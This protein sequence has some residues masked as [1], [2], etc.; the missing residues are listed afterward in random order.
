MIL[1]SAGQL[2]ITFDTLSLSLYLSLKGCILY[3][4]NPTAPSPRER[5]RI[6]KANYI[7]Q[8]ELAEHA[9]TPIISPLV[10]PPPRLRHDG[11]FGPSPLGFF[12][13]RGTEDVVYSNSGFV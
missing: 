5:E 8:I 12:G 4:T 2:R 9:P 13:A 7:Q 11:T 6:K 1:H 10:S 3:H